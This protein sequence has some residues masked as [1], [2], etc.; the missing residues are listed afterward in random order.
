LLPVHLHLHCNS[1]DLV[2]CE[3]GASG[4]AGFAAKESLHPGR[5]IA[6]PPFVMTL[7][8]RRDVRWLDLLGFAAATAVLIGFCMNS[9]VHLRIAALAS[10]VLFVLYG[11]FAHIYPVA[12]LHIILLPINLQ[13]LHRI[14]LEA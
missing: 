10:N 7:R 4:R 8:R 3:S 5:A 14:R 9:I 12:I 1:G 2:H 11:F 6:V 13:K